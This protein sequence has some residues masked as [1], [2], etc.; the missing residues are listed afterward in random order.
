MDKKKKKL[1]A[2]RQALRL[3]NSGNS[4]N[5]SQRVWDSQPQCL[6]GNLPQDANLVRE[7]GART[8]TKLLRGKRPHTNPPQQ[9]H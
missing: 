5:Q 9:L 6:H 3:R 1:L 4:N 2:G 7:S 8:L